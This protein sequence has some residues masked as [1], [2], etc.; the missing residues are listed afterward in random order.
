MKMERHYNVDTAILRLRL[1]N[2]SVQVSVF[3]TEKY[4]GKREISFTEPNALNRLVVMH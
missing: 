3:S 1:K 4:T 2:F